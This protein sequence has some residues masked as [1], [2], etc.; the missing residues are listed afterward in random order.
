MKAVDFSNYKFRCSSLGKLMTTPKEQITEKQLKTIGEMEIKK[1]LKGLTDKQQTELDRLIEKRD[2]SPR[3]SKTTMTYLKEVYIEEVFGRHK[4]LESKY[5]DK[6]NFAEEDSLTLVT[7]VEKKMYVKNKEEL[8]NDFISGTPDVIEKDEIIDIKTCWDIYTFFD[9]DESNKDYFWQLQGYMKLKEY[10]KARLIY[11]LVDTPE[12]LI[13]SEKT[14]R[15]YKNLI[16]EG[17][18]EMAEMEA[19]VELNMTFKDIPEK[20]RMKSF[21]FKYDKESMDI[22]E[23]RIIASREYLSTLSGL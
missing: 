10:G 20:M 22:L 2:N 14:R 15:T 23:G 8:S 13:V 21:E 9:K 19:E 17:S 6:G 12:H 7:N 11:T 5:L 18:K 1:G 16:E 4:D 3:L